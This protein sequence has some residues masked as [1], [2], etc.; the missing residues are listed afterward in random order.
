MKTQLL[1]DMIDDSHLWNKF[2]A[3]FQQTTQLHVIVLLIASSLPTAKY[4]YSD[5]RLSP[6]E[7]LWCNCG[8]HRS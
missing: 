2:L 4:L 7:G 5:M 1:L 3:L 8:Y 6:Q